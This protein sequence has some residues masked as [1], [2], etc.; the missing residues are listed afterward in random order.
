MEAERIEFAM[1]LSEYIMEGRP[2]IYFDETTFNPDMHQKKAWFFKGVRF[3]MPVKKQSMRKG[4]KYGFTVYG[5][6]SECIKG[7]GYFEIHNSSNRQDFC[8]YMHRLRKKIIKV[9]SGLKPVCVLDNLSAHKGPDRR[10]VMNKFCKTEFTPTYSCEL[11]GPI[12]TCW[13]ILKRRVLPRFTELIIKGTANKSKLKA[14]VMD[15]L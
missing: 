4:D 10:E 13:A 6:V 7:G 9:P 12:E 1:K 15:E 8:G 11:N 2:V 5:S 3:P 14:L